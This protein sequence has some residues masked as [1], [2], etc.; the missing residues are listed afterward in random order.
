M[1][2]VS[3][4]KYFM[5]VAEQVSTRATCDRLHVGSVIV[6]NKAILSTGYNG[7]IRGTD[8]CD[9]VGHDIVDNHC[10]RTV[11]SEENAIVQAARNGVKIDGADIYITAFPC[12]GCFRLIANAGIKRIFYKTGYRRNGRVID[13]AKKIGIEIIQ[14]NDEEV[15]AA[16]PSEF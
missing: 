13:T 2:R 10:V 6:K 12:W 16:K 9:D 14:L 7:S 4:E 3:W 11:H 15:K 1:A 5:N 8:H